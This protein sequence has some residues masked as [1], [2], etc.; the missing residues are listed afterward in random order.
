MLASRT[1]FVGAADVPRKS[2]EHTTLF[3]RCFSVKSDN[4]L[5]AANGGLSP[6]VVEELVDTSVPVDVYQSPVE[7]LSTTIL[8]LSK[9]PEGDLDSVDALAD[10]EWVPKDFSEL[11]F[12]PS[13]L[14][15]KGL[16]GVHSL[17]GLPWW[18]TI[19]VTTLV[20][21]CCL[22]PIALKGMKGAA[23]MAVVKPEIDDIKK[24]MEERKRQQGELSQDEQLLFINE[25]KGA[26]KKHGASPMG[27][28]VPVLIQMPLFVS[29]FFGLKKMHEY[30]PEFQTGGAYFFQDLSVPDT[31]YVLPVFCA[32]AF[33]LTIEMGG[34]MGEAS[35]A[36]T[37]KNF[38]R[39]MALGMIPISM[40]FPCSVLCY[41]CTNNTYSL[42]QTTLLQQ[43]FFRSA[44]GLPSLESMKALQSGAAIKN[45]GLTPFAPPSNATVVDTSANEVSKKGAGEYPV[46]EKGL[47]TFELPSVNRSMS[48]RRKRKTSRRK[49]RKD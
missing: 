11:G 36:K 27:G 41:W 25:M 28:L 46:D 43:A 21:R 17:T 12:Y 29:F 48:G 32:T 26:M 7:N 49:R 3:K 44:V 20:A 39:L 13:D 30:V 9:A 23:K 24:R 18:G 6:D 1:I 15:V 10:G 45:V 42:L 38:L 8:A 16:D 31:T 33:L 47:P 19:V 5:L 34:E 22:F 4:N 40:S 37:M 35:Q 14:V 2:A